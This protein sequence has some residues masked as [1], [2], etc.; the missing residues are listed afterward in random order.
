MMRLTS[1]LP[2]QHRLGGEDRR[3]RQVA[4][5]RPTATTEA[6][7]SE[8][9]HRYKNIVCH[10]HRLSQTFWH[11]NPSAMHFH[12]FHPRPTTEPVSHSLSRPQL[13]TSHRHLHLDAKQ[14]IS[15]QHHSH[16]RL[17]RTS[18]Q[19]WERKMIASKL[20][21][22]VPA[23]P[24]VQPCS[25]LL[26]HLSHKRQSEERRHCRH[27]AISQ[28]HRPHRQRCHCARLT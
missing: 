23:R 21:S 19:L 4:R 12:L 11:R 1:P 25:L 14:S 10:L 18:S 24:R 15:R 8:M 20:S 26:R 7:I 17:T 22:L 6:D 27:F 5:F 16:L 3:Q 13:A 28:F 2:D 9:T